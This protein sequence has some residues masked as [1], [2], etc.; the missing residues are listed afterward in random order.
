M[1]EIQQALNQLFGLD[2]IGLGRAGN[3]Q[4]FTFGRHRLREQDKPDQLAD[5]ALHLSCP[6]RLTRDHVISCGQTD[7]ERPSSLFV[8]DDEYDAG[9]IGSRW[10]DLGNAAFRGYLDQAI[11]TVINVETDVFGG[12]RLHMAGA[13]SLDV[14]PAA[15][16]AIHDDL[17]FWRLFQPRLDTPHFIVSSQGISRVADT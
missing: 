10:V 8:S 4:H 3:L 14:F 6:W 1:Q 12:F 16:K 7:L 15:S 9:K 11:V 13:V 2:L 5:F 17:E